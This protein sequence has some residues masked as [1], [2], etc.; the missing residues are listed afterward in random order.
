M[1]ILLQSTHPEKLHSASEK[2]EHYGCGTSCAVK[3]VQA[4]NLVKVSS[5]IIYISSIFISILYSF[6][7]SEGEIVRWSTDGSKFIVQSG[8]TIDLYST[9]AIL[10]K[11][12]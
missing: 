12:S 3:D 6:Y 8:S 2:T 1:L 5:S 9:V 7:F 4:R 10:K 11:F